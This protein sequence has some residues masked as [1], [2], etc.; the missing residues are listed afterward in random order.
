MFH[1]FVTF[2]FSLGIFFVIVFKGGR[3]E[4]C[5]VTPSLFRV[6]FTLVAPVL[7]QKSF[8][9]RPLFNRGT[10][11][12]KPFVEAL[13]AF[14]FAGWRAVQLLLA[15]F[16]SWKPKKGANVKNGRAGEHHCVKNSL[17]E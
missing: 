9:R 3:K 16:G 4:L 15:F 10:T 13:V 11:V 2:C 7:F 17:S 8:D 1:L 6:F 14:S 12:S 5:E